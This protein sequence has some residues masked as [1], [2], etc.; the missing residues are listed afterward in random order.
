MDYDPGSSLRP[1]RPRVIEELRRPIAGRLFRPGE[2][3]IA[4]EVLVGPGGPLPSP[5]LLGEG[6]RAAGS[7]RKV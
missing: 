5:A 4:G 7:C 2:I 3:D 6:L 1:R